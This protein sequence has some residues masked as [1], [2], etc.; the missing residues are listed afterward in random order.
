MAKGSSLSANPAEAHRRQMQKRETKRNKEVRKQ[1]RETAVLYKDTTKIE[2]KIEQYHELKQTRKLTAAERDKL[3]TLEDELKDIQEKQKEAGVAPRKQ[4]KL[5][6]GAVGYDPLAESEGADALVQYASS[7][8]DSDDGV[9]ADAVIGQTVQ[10]DRDIFDTSAAAGGEDAGDD[11][12]ADDGET[13]LDALP[14]MPPGTP[15]L[16]AADL[17]IGEPWP[18][19]PSGPSPLFIRDNPDT[20]PMPSDRGRGR[21]RGYSR[22]CGQRPQQ[23]TARRGDVQEGRTSSNAALQPPRRPHPYMPRPPVPVFAA[24]QLP[25]QPSGPVLSAEPQVR[26][27]KKELTTMVPSKIARKNKQNVRRQVLA[28]VPTPPQMVVNAAP[29]VDGD[30]GSKAAMATENKRLGDAFGAIPS[31]I[32]GVRFSTTVEPTARDEQTNNG[33]HATNTSAAQ[34]KASLDK[35]YERFMDNMNK[36]M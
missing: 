36:F 7:S 18:P 1:M 35:E 2:R 5:G 33:T 26:D 31:Q 20:A 23:F 4:Q 13:S 11:V 21:G 12:K 9:A 22:G 30:A 6:E 15:P 34:N 10:I 24:R 3:K 28:A 17:G 14:P 29:T 25:P 8:S 19:L 27:L 32:N 16:F